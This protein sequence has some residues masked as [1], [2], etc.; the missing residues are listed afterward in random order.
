G[1]VKV[2]RVRVY[3][4]KDFRDHDARWK[5]DV[6]DEIDYA[7]QLLT[8]M[9]GV[10]L[11]VSDVVE[12]DHTAPD[13]PLRETLAALATAAPD[14]DAHW[15]IRIT[16]PPASPTNA[17]DELGTGELFGRYIVVRGLSS[18]DERAA[19]ERLFP[20]IPVRDAGDAL[21]ARRR[22]RATCLLLHQL[23]H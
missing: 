14:G 12:W 1:D 2:A 23:G 7:N 15:I 9:L 21:D 6:T 19:F 10:R 18:D 5:Q 8:P 4:D 17:Y 20:D 13:A 3:A 16:A 22:H 11:E